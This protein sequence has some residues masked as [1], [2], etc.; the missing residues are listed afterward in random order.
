M[1]LLIQI[2]GAAA[3]LAVIAALLLLAYTAR[4]GAGAALVFAMLGL[5]AWAWWS[6]EI[7][8]WASSYLFGA[9]A[10]DANVAAQSNAA[11]ALAAMGRTQ[12]I[13]AACE[14]FLMVFFGLSFLLAVVSVLR[15]RVRP[16]N[17]FKPKPLRGS[18]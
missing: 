7:V 5:A 18:A 3:W 12:H 6:N 15:Q 17:S 4:N 9:S 11:T 13:G 8:G 2:G 1:E 16:N 14:A 10:V